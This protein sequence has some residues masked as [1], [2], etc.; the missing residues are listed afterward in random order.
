MDK[1]IFPSICIIFGFFGIVN[2]VELTFELPDNARECFYADI[3]KNQSATLEFQ[4][5]IFILINIIILFFC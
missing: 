5:I 2:S 1:T 4:V 3:K